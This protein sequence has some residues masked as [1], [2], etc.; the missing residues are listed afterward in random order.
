[1]SILG[2]GIQNATKYQPTQLAYTGCHIE[3]RHDDYRVPHLTLILYDFIIVFSS[4][5]TADKP[6]SAKAR[7]AQ[8]II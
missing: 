8:S 3:V 4:N 2:C 6:S 5:K 1:M 7:A